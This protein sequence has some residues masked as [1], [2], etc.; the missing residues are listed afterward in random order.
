MFH[1]FGT[2]TQHGTGVGWQSDGRR[3]IVYIQHAKE[4]RIA[5]RAPKS[6]DGFNDDRAE[7]ATLS[8]L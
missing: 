5:S 3:G 2:L 1:T 6:Q 4:R 7:V 8:L